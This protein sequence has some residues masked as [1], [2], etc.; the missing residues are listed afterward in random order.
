MPLTVLNFHTLVLVAV[1]LAAVTAPTFAVD[2][3]PVAIRRWNDG[4]FTIETHWGLTLGVD[5]APEAGP[6][7]PAVDR[8]IHTSTTGLNHVL[9]R[10]PNEV[11]PQWLPAAQ[12]RQGDKNAISV[13]SVRLYDEGPA[14]TSVKVDGVSIAFTSAQAAGSKEIDVSRLKNTTV[15]V[16][17]VDDKNDLI[18]PQLLKNVKA[19]KPAKVMVGGVTSVPADFTKKLDAAVGT[20]CKHADHNT[21]AVSRATNSAKSIQQVTLTTNPWEM[22]ADMDRV[23]AAMEKSSRDSQKVFAKLSVRQLNFKPSNGTHTPRWNTEHMMGRQLL[24]F[25]QIY[26]EIDPTIPVMDLNPKQMPKDYEFA[27]SDWTGVEEARQ[28]QRV[29]DFTRRYAYLFEGHTL[30]KRAPGSR[31]PTLRALLE[32]MQHHYSEHTANTEKKFA[33]PAFPKN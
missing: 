12:A 19:I 7:L 15:L 18:Q 1:S 17:V 16:I 30:D 27:H 8:L 28:T 26:H 24:F 29:G 11:K 9:S 14:A 20:S 33:L 6:K 31:W 32:Q 25:S 2:G 4:A 22:S 10:L 23:F 21:L 13:Q 3:D 5:T